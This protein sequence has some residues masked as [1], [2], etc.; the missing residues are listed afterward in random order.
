MR[1]I[2]FKLLLCLLLMSSCTATAPV[3]TGSITAFV[4]YRTLSLQL[5]RGM[6]EQ[7]VTDLLGQPTNSKLTS[8]GQAV[9]HPWPCK[10]LVY[11]S[12]ASNS[13]V[14][15]FRSTDS[16]GNWIVNSWNA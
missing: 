12:D 3:T 16:A 11:G 5:K 4:D 10:M 15:L 6:S 7:N 13:L 8:C 1:F 2:Q 9:G 14:I